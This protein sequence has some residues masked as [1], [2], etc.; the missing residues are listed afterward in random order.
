MKIVLSLLN[1][2]V[3]LTETPERIAE[4]LTKLGLEVEEIIY[5]GS[6]YRNFV[7]GKVIECSQL[8]TEG[9][10]SLCKVDVGSSVRTIV[11]GAPNV[12]VGQNVVV[13]LPGAIL[14]NRSLEIEPKYFGNVCSEGMICSESELGIGDDTTGILVLPSDAVAG[15]NF[16]EYFGLDDVVFEIGITPNRADCLSHLG[17]ARELSAYLGKTIHFPKIEL[18]E[19]SAETI[20]ELISVEILDS[21][22]CPRYTAR[23][24]QDGQRTAS[25]RWMKNY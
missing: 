13:A 6:K 5:L 18:K 3:E 10:L 21:E 4:I 7:V 9:K 25:P 17:V 14:P 16:A 12:A 11:C 15:S 20:E 2:F 22:K 23:I 24:I 1:E 19:E 8:S